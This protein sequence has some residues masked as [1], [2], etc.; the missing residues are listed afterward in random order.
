MDGPNCPMAFT[1]TVDRFSSGTSWSCL[2]SC[3]CHVKIASRLQVQVHSAPAL[4]PC[5]N[6]S[7][8]VL[9]CFPGLGA[10]A[11][12]CEFLKS[13][14]MSLGSFRLVTRRPPATDRRAQST[15]KLTYLLSGSSGPYWADK[16]CLLSNSNRSS[17]PGLRQFRRLGSGCTS[18]RHVAART[19]SFE[20]PL[21]P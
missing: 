9:V 5:P 4:P 12:G 1:E 19:N 2:S 15:S 18:L 10:G 16:A 6:L 3:A 7:S 17:K 20:S 14:A 13:F 21:C 11:L 8:C